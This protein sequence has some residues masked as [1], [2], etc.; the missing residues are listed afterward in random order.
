M[1]KQPWAGIRVEDKIVLWLKAVKQ[2]TKA[3]SISAV[4]EALIIDAYPDIED[5]AGEINKID[6]KRNQEINRLIGKSNHG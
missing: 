6:E 4:L 2:A 5:I 3:K 1:G